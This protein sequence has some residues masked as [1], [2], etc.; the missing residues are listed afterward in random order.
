[1][2]T[3]ARKIKFSCVQPQ[4]Q[5]WLSIIE[6]NIFVWL[7]KGETHKRN[8]WSWSL[9]IRWFLV[10][11]LLIFSKNEMKMYK[12]P[13]NFARNYQTANFV[14]FCYE[15]N[16]FFYLLEWIKIRSKLKLKEIK[17]MIDKTHIFEIY[18]YLNWFIIVPCTWQ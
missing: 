13:T 14:A 3:I 17:T 8:Q 11:V 9:S 6:L 2:Q 4:S 18:T 1:M 15:I 7:T 5:S 10:N 12:N 16:Y